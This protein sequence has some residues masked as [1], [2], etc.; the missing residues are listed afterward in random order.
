[1]GRPKER[2]YPIGYNSTTIHEHAVINDL[3]RLPAT[4]ANHIARISLFFYSHS[5]Y[6]ITGGHNQHIHSR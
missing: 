1:M 6:Q 3:K 4:S 5:N 2:Y